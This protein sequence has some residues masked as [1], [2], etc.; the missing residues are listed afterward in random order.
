[1]FDILQIILWSIAYLLIILATFKNKDHKLISIPYSAAILNFTWEINALI[2]SKGMWAHI[3]WVSL[4]LLIIIYL[5]YTLNNKKKVIFILFIA[6]NIILLNYL[7]TLTNGV[8]LSCFMIDL[9][10]AIVFLVNYKNMSK[11]FK[12]SIALCKMLG[13]LFAWQYYKYNEI[14]NII[15][16]IVLIINFI[17]F[18][19]SF[20]DNKILLEKIFG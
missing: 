6:L 10:M 4:D 15:G 8:L 13:D 1:M 16:I 18:I 9:I 7:F 11:T 3:L 14:V 17:Y 2:K 12:I 5:I 19:K 20:K